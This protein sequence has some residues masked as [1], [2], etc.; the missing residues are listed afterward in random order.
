MVRLCTVEYGHDDFR[1]AGQ[2][3][4]ECFGVASGYLS[5]ADIAVG[6]ILAYAA[7]PRPH[8]PAMAGHV[9]EG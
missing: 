6:S 5:E 2:A 7:L 4:Y 8:T 9:Q 3:E 1:S